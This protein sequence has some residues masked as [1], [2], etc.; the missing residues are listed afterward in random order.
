MALPA[1]AY[2]IE[3]PNCQ[4]Y[5]TYYG[6]FVLV[7]Y[8][9]AD[10][11]PNDPNS[12]QLKNR[13]VSTLTGIDTQEPVTSEKTITHKYTPPKPFSPPEGY[14]SIDKSGSGDVAGG[15]SMLQAGRNVTFSS[16]FTN[17]AAISYYEKTY[18]EPE[19]LSTEEERMQARQDPAN[20]GKRPIR[21][22][23]VDDLFYFQ[24]HYTEPLQPEDY[25]LTRFYLGGSSKYNNTFYKYERDPETGE[26]QLVQYYNGRPDME[27]YIKS[28]GSDDWTRFGTFHD[29]NNWRFIYEDGTEIDGLKSFNLPAGT[30]AVKLVTD[31]AFTESRISY[32]VGMKLHPTE[33]LLRLMEETT[34]G[35]LYTNG[36]YRDAYT[37]MDVNS[38]LIYD[39]DENMIPTRSSSYTRPEYLTGAYARDEVLYGQ[40]VGHATATMTISDFRRSTSM[41]KSLTSYENDTS[42]KE[43]RLHYGIYAGEYL[44]YGGS[45]T[46]KE[47]GDMGIVHEQRSGTF[48]DLLPKGCVLDAGTLKVTPYRSP[49]GT[50]NKTLA[51]M[52]AY[53]VQF[54]YELE[55]NW[56]GT[57]RTMLTIHM[58]TPEDVRTYPYKNG[59]Y[60]N[61]YS[62]QGEII[63][64]YV[65]T[66][67]L[68][69]PWDAVTDYGVS[70]LNSAAYRSGDGN[71]TAGRPDDGGT[72][73][74]LINSAYQ[75]QKP[76][77]E[78]AAQ[79]QNTQC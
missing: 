39:A 50:D 63:S 31:N 10:L 19:G 29:N 56:R 26:F 1:T 62:D 15:I 8:K 76:D 61:A 28:V 60:H 49:Y 9:R 57:G 33:H 47:I 43:V 75:V 17:G 41:Y 58:E 14:A 48:Y 78:D 46:A 64:G 51:A 73:T 16:V 2:T 65:A 3:I 55:D 7:R 38:L 24:D 72:I 69:Y 11:D 44:Y 30:V 77:K 34:P 20:Y 66:F 54:T 4:Y 23:L 53:D 21:A 25:E 36:I 18:Q 70:L 22:E 27:L 37:I 35:N 6:T 52:D 68:T 12:Y 40:K 42:N 59:Y 67:D 5:D 74:D 32:S 45:D 79:S 71:L 13:A